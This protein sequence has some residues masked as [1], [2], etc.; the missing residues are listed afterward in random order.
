MG[1]DTPFYGRNYG[2]FDNP[3]LDQLLFISVLSGKGEEF[4]RLHVVQTLF[5]SDYQMLFGWIYL[6]QLLCFKRAAV[7][8]TINRKRKLHP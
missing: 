5:Q 2:M 8:H 7:A 6:S 1:P 4:L 3:I